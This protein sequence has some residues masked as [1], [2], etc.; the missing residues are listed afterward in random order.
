VRTALGFIAYETRPELSPNPRM[1]SVIDFERTLLGILWFF[2][3]VYGSPLL[4]GQHPISEWKRC[5]EE[6]SESNL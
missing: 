4:N 3:L 6:A 1:R 2:W 5:L